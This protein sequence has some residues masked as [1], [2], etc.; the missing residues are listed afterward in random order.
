MSEDSSLSLA[1][2][3]DRIAILQ[4]NLRQ[5][6]EQAAG[7]SGGATEERTADRISQQSEELER[8]TA[9]HDALSKK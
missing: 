4:A 7:S 2:L 3:G 6:V 9:Q 5:L 8:L 1:E